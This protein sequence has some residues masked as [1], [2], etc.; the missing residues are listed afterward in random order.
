L[1]HFS[2]NQLLSFQ[3]LIRFS[4]TKNFKKEFFF[5]VSN[6]FIQKKK[7]PKMKNS[8]GKNTSTINDNKNNNSS[9]NVSTI[10]ARGQTL[11]QKEE[12]WIEKI[13]SFQNRQILPLIPSEIRNHFLWNYLTI[14]A[15]LKFILWILLYY[16][17]LRLEFG[18][19]YFIFSIF[20]LM[21]TNLGKRKKGEM[22]AYSVFNKN[23]KALPG[24]LQAS[25]FEAE[26]KHIF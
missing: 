24:S 6:F 3:K 5:K 17:F 1:N 20:V 8:R 9:Q 10:Q 7:I 4:K 16:V 2:K 23:Q 13:E 14:D 26:I 19:V 12:T 22:S 15:I 18:T 25:Q 21:F 11:N